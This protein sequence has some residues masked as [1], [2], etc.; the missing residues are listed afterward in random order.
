MVQ[1]T[2][3]RNYIL[4]I[5]KHMKLCGRGKRGGIS[6]YFEGQYKAAAAEAGFWQEKA[7]FCKICRIARRLQY[8]LLWRCTISFWQH[9]ITLLLIQLVQ[10]EGRRCVCVARTHCMLWKVDVR[11]PSKFSEYYFHGSAFL[12]KSTLKHSHIKVLWKH[13]T[14]HLQGVSV[15]F[16]DIFG[17]C[18]GKKKNFKFQ[19]IHDI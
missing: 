12:K 10:M 15:T 13:C 1:S 14:L 16:C 6:L 17:H 9:W 4:N 18:F 7:A 11:N 3:T 2:Y 8:L 5:V 19:D